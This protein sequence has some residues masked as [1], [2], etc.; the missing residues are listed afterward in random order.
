MTWADVVTVLVVDQAVH[1][2]GM[3][4][5]W[6][7]QIGRDQSDVS[8]EYG[9]VIESLDATGS[10]AN[11]G[12]RTVLYP[13]RP[14]QRFGDDRFVSSQD[15]LRHNGFAL[16]HYHFHAREMPNRSYA[17]P[18]GGDMMYAAALGRACV[19][20]T[21]V[22]EG[23]MNADYYHANSGKGG[24]EVRIDLGEVGM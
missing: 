8:T 9:G 14:S 2:T 3:G 10:G 4:T 1:A 6:W 12:F 16:A 7:E 13:P 11:A 22:G 18:G 21:P 20:V 24:V 15:M 23:R 5:Q 17:G 19:V